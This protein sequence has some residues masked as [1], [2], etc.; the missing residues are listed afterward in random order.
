M[1]RWVLT[2]AVILMIAYPVNGKAE[3]SKAHSGNTMLSDCT[4]KNMGV[5][6]LCVGF[7]QGFVQA[8]LG[9]KNLYASKIPFCVPPEAT[10]GQLRDILIN[11]LRSHPETRHQHSAGLFFYAMHEKFPC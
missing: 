5:R 7:V 10:Y 3:I 1:K 2:F 4:H 6:N 11:Y 9:M 8:V